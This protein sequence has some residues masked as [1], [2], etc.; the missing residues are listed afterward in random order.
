MP[1]VLTAP[2]LAPLIEAVA[3]ALRD[4][5][6]SVVGFPCYDGLPQVTDW[7][8]FTQAVLRASPARLEWWRV[9]VSYEEVWETLGPV[10]EVAVRGRIRGARTVDPPTG[11]LPAFRTLI[12]Q[13]SDALRTSTLG[14]LVDYLEPLSRT[15]IDLPMVEDRQEMGTDIVCHHTDLTVTGHFLV[16]V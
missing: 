1:G 7:Q 15:A 9:D 4:Q 2:P 10:T 11:S 6:A 12:A 14:G 8:A 3:Q 5:V 16:A 13:L